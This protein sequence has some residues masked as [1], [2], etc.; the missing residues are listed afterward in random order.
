MHQYAVLLNPGHN[1]IYFEESKKLSC[2]ELLA[3]FKGVLAQESV[4][5]EE[6]EEIP[7]LI[8]QTSEEL[9]VSERAMLSRLSFA[10]AAFELENVNGSIVLRPISREFQFFMDSSMSSLLKYSGKTNELFTRM[11]INL[12][13]FSSDFTKEAQ[14]CLLDPV[15]GKGT[16]LFEGL[17]LG[18]DVSGIEIGDK[19]AHEACCCLKRY[20]EMQRYKHTQKNERLSGPNKSFTA[21]RESFLIARSKEE[22]REG[23]NRTFTMMAGNSALAD[24]FFPKNSFHI[25]VGDLPYGVQHGNVTNQ[26]Q[27]SLTRNPNELLRACLPGWRKV[28]K[29][30]GAMAL[31]WNRNVL[32]RAKMEELLVHAGFHPLG[33]EPDRFVHRVD[34]SILRDVI[35]ARKED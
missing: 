23:R 20:L 27:S 1:R 9:S 2:S 11:M 16:T 32:A 21:A 33:G 19:A 26:K 10:Y 25:I 3:V 12:A 17:S 35:I 15:A 18:Y 7:Y 22:Q 34:Q 31:A 29:R 6:I 30:G 28:L 4:K 14:I 8:F 13:F 24:Q 5:I